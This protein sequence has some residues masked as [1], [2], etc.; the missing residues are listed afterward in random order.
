MSTSNNTAAFSVTNEQEFENFAISFAKNSK[1]KPTHVKS[2]ISSVRGFETITAYKENLAASQTDTNFAQASSTENAFKQIKKAQDI[3]RQQEDLKTNDLDE[4]KNL[5]P[6][7]AENCVEDY[8]Y[9]QSEQSTLD[10]VKVCQLAAKHYADSN[11]TS[12]TVESNY[13]DN[14]AMGQNLYFN[15]VTVKH[16][17]DIVIINSVTRVESDRGWNLEKNGDTMATLNGE[18]LEDLFFDD[19]DSL[20]EMICPELDVQFYWDNPVE[21]TLLAKAQKVIEKNNA[22][23]ALLVELED[24]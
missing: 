3:I 5:L 8:N 4:L 2:V 16:G 9:G 6:M 1:L 12:I 7:F 21:P 19:F 20:C 11:Y 18:P 17:D 10:A 24:F 22:A 15:K 23:L 14:D 13:Y